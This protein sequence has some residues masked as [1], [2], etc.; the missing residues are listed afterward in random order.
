VGVGGRGV[1]VTGKFGGGQ[2]ELRSE[3]VV[4]GVLYE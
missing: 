3:Q 4:C 2:R 1:G